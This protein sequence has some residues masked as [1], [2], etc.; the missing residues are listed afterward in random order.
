MGVT[1]SRSVQHLSSSYGWPYTKQESLQIL[2]LRQAYEASTHLLSVRRKDSQVLFLDAMAPEG[3]L[4]Q[5]TQGPVGLALGMA[6]GDV[7]GEIL[8][9]FDS[10][11]ALV[12]GV[13]DGSDVVG[14]ALGSGVVGAFVKGAKSSWLASANIS[15]KAARMGR[16]VG[17]VTYWCCNGRRL[18]NQDRN[19]VGTY[20]TMAHRW[21]GGEH[22]RRPLGRFFWRAKP[23]TREAATLRHNLGPRNSNPPHWFQFQGK[24][25]T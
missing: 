20:S 15:K 17:I 18:A 1:S 25:R 7:V 14:S 12:V 11:G 5:G 23:A 16:V 9:L 2:S 3:S 10:V 21:R 8:G 13:A 24:L 6:V 19:L 4:E 22:G